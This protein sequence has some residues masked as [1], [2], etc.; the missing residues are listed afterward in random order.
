MIMALAESIFNP[1]PK[2]IKEFQE[3]CGALLYVHVH[4]IPDISWALSLLTKYMTKAGPIHLATA[5]TVLCYLHGCRSI[6]ITWCAQACQEPHLPGHI[7]GYADASFVDVK[8][9]RTSSM[10]YVFLIHNAAV[11]W[12][13]TRSSIVVL[14]ACKAE[15]VSLSSACQASIYLC[16]LYYEFRF[17]QTS[18]TIMY[19]DS[20]TSA[21]SA[22]NSDSF[23]HRPLSC[24]RTLH[25]PQVLL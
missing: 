5:K 12:R 24:M 19:E 3:L 4:T 7:Y 6:P 15:V 16:K 21:S 8:P 17:L 20:D 22:M 10:G 2:I 14:N 11:S 1:D 18:P 9:E 23:R 13:S 25:P